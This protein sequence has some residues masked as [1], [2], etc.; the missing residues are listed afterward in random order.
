MVQFYDENMIK[1][2]Q[3]STNGTPLR[4]F[5][6]ISCTVNSIMLNLKQINI[7]DYILL[8]INKFILT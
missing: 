6:I 7:K 4:F 3:F 2:Q 5:K 1:L 8:K